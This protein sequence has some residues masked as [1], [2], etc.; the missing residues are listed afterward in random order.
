VW[1][2][3]S[4][5]PTLNLAQVIPAE[6]TLRT[7]LSIPQVQSLV[8]PNSVRRG[9][10][11]R[12]YVD[13]KQASLRRQ[14]VNHHVTSASLPVGVVNQSY[15]T[16]LTS[17]GGNTGARIWTITAG[18]LPPGLQLN[19]VSG[20]ISGTRLRREVSPLRRRSW[21]RARLSTPQRAIGHHRCASGCH[22][23]TLADTRWRVVGSPY[24]PTFSAAGGVPTYAW[25]STG[26][27][28]PGLT[29]YQTPA[30]LAACRPHLEHIRS[31]HGDGFDR[32]L[33]NRALHDSCG[34]RRPACTD[35]LRRAAQQF[36]GLPGYLPASASSGARR[37][38]GSDSRRP[39]SDEFGNPACS[40]A[41]S[42]RIASATTN[43]SGIA[44]FPNLLIDRG[45]VGYTLLAT[46]GNA[47]AIS[48]PFTVNGF[49]QLRA[50][51]RLV[52]YTRKYS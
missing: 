19:A 39:G 34:E 52:N 38:R 20:A 24:H 37:V 1:Q 46:A 40:T 43:A 18:S 11:G 36:C 7:N 12:E 32:P 51:L 23:H 29:L 48:N 3:W 27:L 33:R 28:P 42:F 8:L 9:V 31:R 16:V 41:V 6:I 5:N 15:N 2:I 50:F 22:H 45:Q 49:C 47:T 17:V 13:V 4:A 30:P 35:C 44:S 26:T 21:T 25:S 10:A 14:S